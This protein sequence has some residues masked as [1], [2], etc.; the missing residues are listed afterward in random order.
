[1]INVHRLL[2]VFLVH[3]QVYYHEEESITMDFHNRLNLPV[4]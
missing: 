3:G 1:M 4:K 2:I